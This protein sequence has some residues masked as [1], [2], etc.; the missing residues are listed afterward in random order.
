MFAFDPNLVSPYVQNL[1]MSLTHR[2]G[3]KVTLE[4]KYIGTLSRKLWANLNLNEENFM[5]NGLLDAF[6]TA[7]RGGEHPL[8]DQIFRGINMDGSGRIGIDP[9]ATTA[10]NFL[11]TTTQGAVAL[12]QSLAQGDYQTLSNSLSE[13]NYN[14]SLN[15]G[16]PTIL[17]GKGHVLHV[18]M[19][20]NFIHPN[21]QFGD[22]FMRT[23]LGH[24]NYHSF[25]GQF[26]LQPTLG[27]NLQASYTWSKDLGRGQ[28]GY[29][30]PWDRAGDY[31]V[32]TRNREHQFRTYGTFRLPIGPN[33]LLFGSSSGLGARI[34]EGWQMS[35][36]LNLLSGLPNRVS[37]QNMII[38]A[39][40]ANIVG[41]FDVHSANAVWQEGAVAG[42]LFG[43]RFVN[44][45]DPQC[46]DTSIVAA[47]LRTFC[48][49]GLGS[50]QDSQTGTIIFRNPLP[51][52]RGSF[53]QN[54]LTGPGTWTT[55]MAVSKRVQLNEGVGLQIRMDATNIFNHPEPVGAVGGFFGTTESATLNINSATPFGQLGG[56]RGNRQFQLK[57]RLDF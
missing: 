9:G 57:M 16:L 19:P 27:V 29:T 43:G 28:N 25:Q 54:N 14:S 2:V 45:R 26:T 46:A 24:S 52:E 51:G 11:R 42:N 18:N 47:A 12:R 36:I 40:S 37:A 17:S 30:A 1:T 23:N 7:R 44:V 15:P 4:G 38:G 3:R 8:L 33:Q 10:G 56:K 22:A 5:F 50:I 55:D 35:W 48:E 13:L 31:T 34:A 49:T 21:P 6:N 32:A 53:G 39:G 41:P 20:D